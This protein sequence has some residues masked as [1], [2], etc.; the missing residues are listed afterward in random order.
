MKST[1]TVAVIIQAVLPELSTETASAVT[2]ASSAMSV[3]P[4]NEGTIKN[5]NNRRIFSI[6]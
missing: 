3:V 6:V 4:S 2:A 1:S 5:T